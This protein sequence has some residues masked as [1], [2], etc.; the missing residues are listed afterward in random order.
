MLQP[1]SVKKVRATGPVCVLSTDKHGVTVGPHCSDDGGDLRLLPDTSVSL[2][3]VVGDD[4]VVL[5][6]PSHR[7]HY[8]AHCKDNVTKGLAVNTFSQMFLSN[9]SIHKSLQLST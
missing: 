1:P 8:G 4:G 2:R 6:L 5:L 9:V 3:Q 7:T